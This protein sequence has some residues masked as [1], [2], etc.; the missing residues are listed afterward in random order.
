MQTVIW[1]DGALIAPDRPAISALD[2]GLLLG[3]GVFETIAVEAGMPFALTRHLRRLKNSAQIIG[4]DLPDEQYLR[5][6]VTAALEAWNAQAGQKDQVLQPQR[7]RMRLTI[8][9][10]S[11]D[12]GLPQED[13][14]EP[15]VVVAIAPAG[16]RREAGSSQGIKAL[17]SPWPTNPRSPLA[18][19]KT[20]SYASHAVSQRYARSR[21][22]DELLSATTDGQLCE[23]ATSNVFVETGGELLTPALSVGCL[24][25]ITRELILEWS[26]AAGLPVREAEPGELPLEIL[27]SAD[28][29]AVTGSVRG[30]MPITKMGSRELAPGPLTEEVAAIFARN[31]ATVW[32]P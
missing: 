26:P 15:T 8:T 22:V 1:V 23:G 28:H 21:G 20:L 19:A 2:R 29:L 32:D 11:G 10:G 7:G 5:R 16:P 27:D 31:S 25:G 30:I 4:L 13:D 3:F 17:V 6:G 12:L 24:P 14:V 9:G 18:G